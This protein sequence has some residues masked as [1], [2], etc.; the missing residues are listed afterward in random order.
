MS[1]PA[2]FSMLGAAARKTA[3]ARPKNP[4]S[5]RGLH[6]GL[7]ESKAAL[8]VGCL[9]DLGGPS[10]SKQMSAAMIDCIHLGQVNDKTVR[11]FPG[12]SLLDDPWAAWPDTLAA[13]RLG[14]L[15]RALKTHRLR[16]LYGSAIIDAETPAGA[17]LIVPNWMAYAV[18]WVQARDKKIATSVKDEFL[19]ATKFAKDLSLA[20]SK[21]A[22]HA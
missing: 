15:S 22:G 18:I 16:K 19:R 14:R 20:A 2:A 8:V 11:L 21:A 4:V 10:N 13:A 1:N 5:S 6:M 3:S 12:E 9:G 7:A 17:V